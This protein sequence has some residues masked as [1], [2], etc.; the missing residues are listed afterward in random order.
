M[1]RYFN[2]AEAK[3]IREYQANA[4]YGIDKLSDSDIESIQEKIG[5]HGR[6]FNSLGVCLEQSAESRN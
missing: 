3:F 2:D 4:G 5:D 6:A 1:E